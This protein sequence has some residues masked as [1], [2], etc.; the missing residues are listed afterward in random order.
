VGRIAQD[1]VRRMV[2]GGSERKAIDIN[3]GYLLIFTIIFEQK[4]P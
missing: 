4:V 2:H 1:K 3:R